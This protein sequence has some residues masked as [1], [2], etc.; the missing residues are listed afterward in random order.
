[1]ADERVGMGTAKP[2][3]FDLYEQHIKERGVTRPKKDYSDIGLRDKV[4][5]GNHLVALSEMQHALTLGTPRSGKTLHGSCTFAS[6]VLATI[7]RP[8]RKLIVFDTKGDYRAFLEGIH[9]EWKIPIYYQV[10]NVSDLLCSSWDI[11]ADFDD[12]A[13]LYELGY[14]IFPEVKGENAFFQDSARAVSLA[15]M[16]SFT[17][18]H[19]QDWTMADLYNAL[20]SDIKTLKEIIRG[21]PRGEEIVQ[22]LLDT[23]A[24]ETFDSIRM[25]IQAQIERLRIP[26]AHIQ[27]SKGGKL[28]LKEFLASPDDQILVISQD[29]TAEAVARPIVQSA[30]KRLTDFIN[31]REGVEIPPDTFIFLD[32]LEFIG[33]LPGLQNAANFARGKGLILFLMTQTVEGL[34]RVYGKETAESIMSD[35]PFKALFRN[36]SLTTGQWCRDLIGKH[37]IWENE[38]TSGYS[39]QSINVSRVRKRIREDAVLASDLRKLPR[40]TLDSGLTG[41]FLSEEYGDELWKTISSEELDGPVPPSAEYQTSPLN[42]E[43]QIIEHWSAAE[44][45]KYVGGRTVQEQSEPTQKEIAAPLL[46]LFEKDLREEIFDLFQAMAFPRIEEALRGRLSREED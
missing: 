22:L 17:Y 28:S 6:V 25:T 45:A 34:Y 7:S 24:A 42:P 39:N 15:V 8:G 18:R 36:D 12:Y 3:V 4:W 43:D 10:L 31:A 33:K 32:E 37:E 20:T 2:T 19:G 11:A 29:L 16:S 38:W 44:R 35:C 5:W 26:A 41:M 9:L 21:F 13:R 27:R 14:L 40:P 23:R 46:S 30:F 1:M